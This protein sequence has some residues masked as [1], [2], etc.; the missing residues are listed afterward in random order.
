MT[1][2]QTHLAILS[3]TENT[4]L[5]NYLKYGRYFVGHSVYLYK[6]FYSW[7]NSVARFKV[8]Y[9]EKLNKTGEVFISLWVLLWNKGNVEICSMYWRHLAFTWF[10]YIMCQVFFHKSRS[11]LKSTL[12]PITVWVAV[13]NQLEP[14]H[15]V[16]DKNYF[17][18]STKYV[19]ICHFLALTLHSF[20]VYSFVSDKTHNFMTIQ[21]LWSVFQ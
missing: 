1:E 20:C 2:D 9:F 7:L 17:L 8:S 5:N 16:N 15:D 18:C 14:A 6:L 4:S 11:Y 21:I 10:I 12:Y 3:F 13:L 19:W